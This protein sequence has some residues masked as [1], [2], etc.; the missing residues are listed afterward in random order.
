MK[1]PSDNAS[2]Q[3]IQSSSYQE[4]ALEIILHFVLES[5]CLYMIFVKC[6]RE[7]ELQR[8]LILDRLNF[9]Q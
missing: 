5:K 8:G 3:H 9:R 7:C 2:K 6:V 1:H 4:P